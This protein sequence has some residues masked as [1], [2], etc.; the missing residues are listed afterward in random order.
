MYRSWRA[1]HH[2]PVLRLA[3]PRPSG[4][5]PSPRRHPKPRAAA[6]LTPPLRTRRAQDPKGAQLA[7][8]ARAL[9]AITSYGRWG[10]FWDYGSLLQHERTE[11]E[12]ELFKQGL[13]FLGSFYSHPQTYV[14]RLTTFPEGYPEGYDLPSAANVAAYPDRGCAAPS[15]CPNTPPTPPSPSLSAPPLCAF[16]RA[17]CTHSSLHAGGASPSRAGRP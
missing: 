8:V 15:P 5:P 7:V 2:L 17:R 6:A 4:E 12:T 14:F 10:V 16:P 13:G 9:K 1:A 3:A 11:A